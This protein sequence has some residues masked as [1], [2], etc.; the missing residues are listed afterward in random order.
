[1]IEIPGPHFP[2]VREEVCPDYLCAILVYIEKWPHICDVRFQ[3]VSRFLWKL[4]ISTLLFRK[5]GKQVTTLVSQFFSFFECFIP[6]FLADDAHGPQSFGTIPFLVLFRCLRQRQY[7]PAF[8]R[9]VQN[10][11]KK[12]PPPR[13]PSLA[14]RTPFV[15]FFLTFVK[16]CSKLHWRNTGSAAQIFLNHKIPCQVPQA[17]VV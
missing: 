5:P 9:K 10:A 16:L 11:T 6:L 12:C 14:P 3:P 17:I 1:M 8:P 15:H 4:K 2:C 7:F 13:P